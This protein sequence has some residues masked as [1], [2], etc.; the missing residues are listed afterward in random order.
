MKSFRRWVVGSVYV[1]NNGAALLGDM[2]GR[3]RQLSKENNYGGR[4]L[5]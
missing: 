5:R 1:G 2:P 4:R 3:P